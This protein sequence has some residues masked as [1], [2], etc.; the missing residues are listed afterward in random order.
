MTKTL[1]FRKSEREII[2]KFKLGKSCAIVVACFF[3]S[4]L[5]PLL[6]QLM[7]L[8][9]SDYVIFDAWINVIVFVNPKLDSLIFF[10]KSKMLGN[11]AKKVL[12]IIWC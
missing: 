6:S 12:K 4:F 2:M 7:P 3:I 5:L 9:K 8:S 1:T 11:E 10:L